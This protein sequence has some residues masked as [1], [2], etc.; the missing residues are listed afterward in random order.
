MFLHFPL[1]LFAFSVF[2]SLSPTHVNSSHL[3]FLISCSSRPAIGS[4]G[5]L[6]R[7][8]AHLGSQRWQCKPRPHTYKCSVLSI[9]RPSSSLASTQNKRTDYCAPL[10]SFDW[11][12]DGLF[13]LFF[14]LFFSNTRIFL[15]RPTHF[16]HIQY[17]HHLHY[18]GH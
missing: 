5:Y 16:G 4:H 15:R 6:W 2:N 13:V 14:S 18:L 17:R 7:L 12:D 3:G 10:T 11:N 1:V 8:H 9:L